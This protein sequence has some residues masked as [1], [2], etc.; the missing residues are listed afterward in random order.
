MMPRKEPGY[1]SKCPK[2]EELE[3]MYAEHTAKELAEYY[4]VSEG[5]IRRWIRNY[6]NSEAQG[7]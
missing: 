5:T 6:R 2:R 7:V 4:E 3:R 1:S